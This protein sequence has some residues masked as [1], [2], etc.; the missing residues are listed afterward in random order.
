M[1]PATN[2]PSGFN[3]FS[4]PAV[5]SAPTTM[6]AVSTPPVAPP[7][8][9][10]PP[11]RV[12]SPVIAEQKPVEPSPPPAPPATVAP[13]SYSRAQPQ[14]SRKMSRADSDGWES[15]EEKED[16]DDSSDDDRENRKKL[17]AHLFG[18]LTP[19]TPRPD[20]RASN[21]V[22][23]STQTPVPT[24]S[25]TTYS[26]PPPAPP[27]PIISQPIPPAPF[28]IPDA[29][30]PPPAPFAPLPPSAP[31]ASVGGGG[32]RNALLQSITG[33]A[34]LRPTK[35][36]DRSGVLGAGAVL[37]DSAP[38]AHILNQEN[39][40]SS[41]PEPAPVVTNGHAH[42]ES[43]DWYADLAV[44]VGSPPAPPPAPMLTSVAEEETTA[45]VPAITVQDEPIATENDPLED[46]D[47]ATSGCKASS[48]GVH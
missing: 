48:Q 2:T 44:D 12:E 33:G 24:G 4:R 28:A 46:V 3:P 11:A 34:R 31:I 18:S 1:S 6:P 30:A 21:P 15:I 40:R 35:T 13:V 14:P 22:R 10:A 20:S 17:A 42:K 8:P 26:P 32:E 37:G 39:A 45:P 47:M 23:S 27:A 19:A 29:P 38:P 9:P 36:V 43:V 7:P 16:D 25:A 41:S 5:S